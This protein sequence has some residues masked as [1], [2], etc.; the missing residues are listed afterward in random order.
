MSDLPTCGTVK[1]GDDSVAIIDCTK[2][3][4]VNRDAVCRDG[5]DLT[6]CASCPHRVG[7]NGN[8][9]NPPIFALPD[10]ASVQQEP[11]LAFQ[12]PPERWKGLG[13]VVASATKMVGI[14]PCGPCSK[15]REALNRMVPFGKQKPP[16]EG[17][18][19]AATDG[20]EKNDGQAT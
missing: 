19:P 13:D 6:A 1:F 10:P 5:H 16:S 18:L 11:E 8:M 20:G 14:K 17:Q 3:Q 4:L 12:N 15:R 2:W 7:R 9:T